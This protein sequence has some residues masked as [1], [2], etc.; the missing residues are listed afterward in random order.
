MILNE[1]PPISPRRYPV[2][3][4]SFPGIIREHRLYID[5]TEI[6]YNL[7]RNGKFYFLSRPRRFGKSL[8]L[9]TLKAFFQGRKELFKGLAIAKLETEWRTHPVIH[10]SMGSSDFNSRKALSAHLNNAVNENARTLGVAIDGELPE[11]RF[12]NLI[13]AARDKYGEHVVV[14]VDEYDKPLLDT[15]HLDDALHEEIRAQ[16]RGFYG[17][18]KDSGEH[19]RFVM[20]TGVTKFSHVNIFSGLNNLDDISLD[21]C[22]NAICGISESEMHTNFKDDMQVFAARNNMTPEQAAVE[23]KKHYDGYRFAAVGENIYNPFSVICAFSKM[24]FNNYWYQSGT[25]YYLIKEMERSHFN[26]NNLEGVSVSRDDLMGTRVS[27]HNIIALLYQAGYLTIKDYEP[28][29]KTY[30]LGF[31]NKEVSSGFT[32][33]FWISSNIRNHTTDIAHRR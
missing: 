31:P 11:I 20:L 1:M 28:E 15:R 30:I 23:F 13:R 9:S 3:D 24:E 27:A 32:T 14:L 18:I 10:L 17:C 25:S 29:S 4:S 16:L 26:F 12:S 5:K 33:T 6:L 21:P 19:I 8:M 22:Y 7:I 2:G